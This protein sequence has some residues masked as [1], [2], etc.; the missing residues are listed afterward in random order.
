R[1]GAASG[2]GP[3]VGEATIPIAAPQGSIKSP[4]TP[5]P[6]ADKRVCPTCG[7]VLLPAMSGC[8][9][10]AP[11]PAQPHEA[12]RM[13]TAPAAPPPAGQFAEPPGAFGAPGQQ[14]IDLVD[15]AN[16]GLRIDLGAQPI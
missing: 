12:T 16:R 2:A 14:F 10:C 6:A 15:G 1:R 4:V 11:A 3:V 9:F 5:I 8:P 13:G 7:K